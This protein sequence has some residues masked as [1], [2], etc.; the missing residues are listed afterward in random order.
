[1]AIEGDELGVCAVNIA[2]LYSGLTESE[3]GAAQ[4]LIGNLYYYE[5]SRDVARAAG[6]YRFGFARRG[7]T[8][9]V[10]DTLVAA[11]AVNFGAI[12][13]TANVKDYPM[14]DIELRQL[15]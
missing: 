4:E 7:T 9:T 13:L 11:T 14:T 1:M 12:L 8:L 6:Q 10:T 5:I 2:E 3:Q 15:P